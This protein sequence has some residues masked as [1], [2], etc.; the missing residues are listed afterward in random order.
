MMDRCVWL[1][2]IKIEKKDTTSDD[3]SNLNRG[4]ETQMKQNGNEREEEGI[5]VKNI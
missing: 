2:E 4:R 3:E 5:D 1:H